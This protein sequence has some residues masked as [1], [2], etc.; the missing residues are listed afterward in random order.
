MNKENSKWLRKQVAPYE[1]ANTAAS[2]RQLV[3]TILPFCL[4]W[5]LAYES[6]SVSYLLTLALA[7]VGAGFMTRIFIIFHDCCHYSFFKSRKAN[8]IVGTITGILTFSHIIN[9]SIAILF[10]MRQAEILIS[11]EQETFG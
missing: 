4:I 3:N 5:Y 9:G 10:I 6:L 11:A 8:K 7:A 1:K 2:V